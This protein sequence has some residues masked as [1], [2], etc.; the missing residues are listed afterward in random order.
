MNNHNSHSN[1]KISA[2]LWI[3][4]IASACG[5]KEEP[6]AESAAPVRTA[7]VERTSIRRL[8]TARAILYPSDQ[9]VVM[10][11]LS[12]MVKEFYVNKGDHV[13]KGQLLAQLENSD[14]AASAVEAKSM[15]DEAEA[16]YQNTT[17]ATLPEEISKAHLE[18]QSAKEALDA[19]Q[20]LYESRRQLLEEGALP[21]RQVDEANVAFVQ[22]RNQYEAAAKHLEALEKVGREAGARQAK[23]QLE[24]AKGR[25]MNAQAQL[26]YARITSPLTG[27][28]T[29][30]P[31]YAGEM[32]SP[33]TPLLTV[34]DISH[35]IARANVPASQLKFLKVGDEA[36]ILA[37]DSSTE[38][39]GKVTVISSA[40]DQ[41]STTAEVWV[42][43]V[44][45]GESLKPG[46]A[47]EVSIVS[48]V[49]PDAL[50]IPPA[51]ILP[52]DEGSPKVLVV[53]TDSLAHAR[54]VEI[55]IREPD[56]VQVLKGLEQGESV[57]VIG[58]VGLE[59]KSKVRIEK[60]G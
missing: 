51:A 5:H 55:G 31:M 57:I 47:V 45:P 2:L 14:L 25:Y 12:A 10:P 33:S 49:V 48:E 16:S 34:M 11:K 53:G 39:H 56:K 36:T 52:T 60:A 35:L 32:A 24:A 4:F 6:A 44:N 38:L 46:T 37:A 30:R 27:V 18:V 28:V 43:A 41:N 20:K 15:V 40:L 42:K 54:T 22:A 26:E 58:G 50:V 1:V 3:V 13:R 59:D 8:I 9:A 19:A 29:D 23:A 7:T 17:A 21:R